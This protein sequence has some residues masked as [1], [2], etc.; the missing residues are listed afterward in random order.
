MK[1]KILFPWLVKIQRILRVQNNFGHCKYSCIFPVPGPWSRQVSN[2]EISVWIHFR[3]FTRSWIQR[4]KQTF[5][6]A[7]KMLLP[8]SASVQNKSRPGYTMYQL[9]LYHLLVASVPGT[10][11]KM[12]AEW[13]KSGKRLVGMC[14]CVKYKSHENLFWIL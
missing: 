1:V 11:L 3:L 2:S 5:H 14:M 4:R 8:L 6:S 12:N 10:C 13:A 7:E 9:T